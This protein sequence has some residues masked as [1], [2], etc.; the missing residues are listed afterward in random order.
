L[1]IA[2]AG[3]LIVDALVIAFFSIY[4]PAIPK[5]DAIIILGAAINT[6][7]LYNRSMEGL[8]LYQDGKANILVLSG[9]RISDQDISEAKYMDKVITKNAQGLV[10]VMLEDQSHTTYE[11]IKNSKALLPDAKSIIVVS[12]K[13]HLARAV[14]VA[15]RAGFAHV[16]WA[17]P[18]PYYFSKSELAYYYMREEF[19]MIAYIPKFIFN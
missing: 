15:K 4:R 18:Q 8:R 14:L 16:Y 9:G 2:A 7:A 17:A 1:L 3:I 13:F 11:N 19:A 5:A 6:P 12:D 10:P